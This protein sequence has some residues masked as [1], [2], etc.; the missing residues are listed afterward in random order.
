[1]SHKSKAAASPST[2]IEQLLELP[3]DELLGALRAKF[4][5]AENPSLEGLPKWATELLVDK[6]RRRY[7]VTAPATVP[8]V[9]A[10]LRQWDLY[11]FMDDEAWPQSHERFT[12]S[13]AL[14]EAENFPLKRGLPLAH[15]GAAFA[16][17]SGWGAVLLLWNP[18]EPLPEFMQRI[19]DD[20][21]EAGCYYEVHGTGAVHVLV[22]KLEDGQ[23]ADELP[24]LEVEGTFVRVMIGDDP[25]PGPRYTI[26][27][28]GVIPLYGGGTLRD[29][30]RVGSIRQAAAR[31][32]EYAFHRPRQVYKGQYAERYAPG[33]AIA[34]Q[35]P[36]SP[37]TVNEQKRLTGSA[38]KAAYVLKGL[39][40][41]GRQLS[42]DSVRGA[43]CG[44]H[45]GKGPGAV[46][47]AVK[48]TTDALEARGVL[49]KAE[50]N[51]WLFR[52]EAL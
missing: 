51:G 36:E 47:A 48:R 24:L 42:A 46:R 41:G 33:N 18:G 8:A 44:L 43:I 15:R 6:S 28:S 26:D 35:R 50:P 29:S 2:V 38:L 13:E 52:G 1:M 27:S 5:D 37:P 12:L 21:V 10:E 9:L 19:V 11:G 40:T 31:A 39:A 16:L 17:H 14:K 7:P 3:Q 49:E 34:A 23:A 45:E 22:G 4:P 32:F 25:A 30:Q 20:A